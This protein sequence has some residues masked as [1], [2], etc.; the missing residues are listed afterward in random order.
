M[1]LARLGN[2]VSQGSYPL[3]DIQRFCPLFSLSSS[4]A[5]DSNAGTKEVRGFRRFH[6]RRWIEA[7]IELTLDAIAHNLMKLRTK[8]A[9]PTDAK[10]N[11]VPINSTLCGG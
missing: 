5:E 7:N 6:L 3:F 11:Q 9:K 1:A 8:I 10:L 2:H 4:V